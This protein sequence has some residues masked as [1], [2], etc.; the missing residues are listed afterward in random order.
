MPTGSGTGA[1]V[2]ERKRIARQ[3]QAAA[4]RAQLA[5]LRARQIL[6]GKR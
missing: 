1:T 4:H 3:Q 2:R 5:K 6:A